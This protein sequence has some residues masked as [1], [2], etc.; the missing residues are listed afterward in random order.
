MDTGQVFC[1]NASQ[2]TQVPKP[3]ST[4]TE[5]LRHVR[6]ECQLHLDVHI[7]TAATALYGLSL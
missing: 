4:H 2:D 7:W 3:L 6:R 5:G 1:G